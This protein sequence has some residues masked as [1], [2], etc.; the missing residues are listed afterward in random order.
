MA[1]LGKVP[2]TIIASSSVVGGTAYCCYQYANGINK[3]GSSFLDYE[4]AFLSTTGDVKLWPNKLEALKQGDV[5][6]SSQK[7][8]DA[9]SRNDLQLLKE[10]CGEFYS[11]EFLSKNSKDID[12][13][14][15]YCAKTN[16]DVIG[17]TWFSDFK[18]AT[19]AEKLAQKIN[20]RGD[21]AISPELDGILK[22]YVGKIRDVELAKEISDWCNKVG[23]NIYLGP[24]TDFT[25]SQEYC[26]ALTP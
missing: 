22:K 9:K 25:N 2:V 18:E 19:G 3:V 5:L 8:K 1:L 6:G 20:N 16:K 17:D 4:T 11:H 12:D 26:K 24:L 21:K 7:L 10:A 23:N 14:K 15:K 13:F